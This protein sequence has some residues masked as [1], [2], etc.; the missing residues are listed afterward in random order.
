MVLLTASRLTDGFLGLLPPL[1]ATPR[2][3]VM[4]RS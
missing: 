4:R 3:V 2:M 1:L